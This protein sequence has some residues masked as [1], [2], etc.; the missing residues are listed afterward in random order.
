[1]EVGTSLSTT[2]EK[3]HGEVRSRFSLPAPGGWAPLKK[4]YPTQGTCRFAYEAPKTRYCP[5]NVFKLQ[6]TYFTFG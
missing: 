6:S 3:Q 5:P 1:M 2:K 4:R